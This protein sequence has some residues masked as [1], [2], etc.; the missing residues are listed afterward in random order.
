MFSHSQVWRAI[1]KVAELNGLSASGLAKRSGLDPTSFNKSKRVTAQGRPRW[2]S[3]ESL[4]KVL[5]ATDMRLEQFTALMSGASPAEIPGARIPLIGLVQAGGGGFFDDAG[6][7]VGA[8]WEE[9]AFPQVD[10]PNAYAL[11]ITGDSMQPVYRDG[12]VIVVSPNGS[13]R[14]GDR[15]VVRTRD[16]E[17][18]AKILQRRNASKVELASF[19][20]E[21]ETRVLRPDEVDWIARV[22]WASQ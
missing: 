7:P 21:H 4:A 15:V 17:V 10:D 5:Q 13:L 22:L 11:E 12:D 3:T 19:N 6:F 1:D 8:G 16:G 20:P 2:P 18:L 14:R 9:I